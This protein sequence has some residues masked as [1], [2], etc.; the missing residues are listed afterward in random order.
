MVEYGFYNWTSKVR[1]YAKF[2]KKELIWILVSIAVMTFILGFDDG[3]SEFNLAGYSVNMLWGLIAVTVAVFMHESAHRLMAPNLGYKVEFKPVFFG[4]LGGLILSF[5]SYGKIVFLAYSTFVLDM[6]EKHRL[7]YFRHYLGYFDN[8]KVAI[9]GPLANLL[10]A[11]A[12]RAMDFLPDALVAKLVFVN[13]LFVIFNMLP[14]PP[15][16]GSHVMYATRTFSPI[17]GGTMIGAA[18]FMLIP[19]LTW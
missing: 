2:S 9:V 13:A 15:L 10:A 1:L 19:Q 7:G 11:F 17:I 18:G 8:G 4:L 6:K 5:M 3:N 12:F 14:I 16:D